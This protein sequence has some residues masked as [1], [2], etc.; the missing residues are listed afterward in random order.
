M[1][2]DSDVKREIDI[3]IGYKTTSKEMDMSEV[4]AKLVDYAKKYADYYMKVVNDFRPTFDNTGIN[5][6]LNRLFFET[7]NN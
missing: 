7:V 5:E 1:V 3:L 4:P 2:S 6:D